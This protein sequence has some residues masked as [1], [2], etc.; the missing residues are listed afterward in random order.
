MITHNVVGFDAQTQNPNANFV[1]LLNDL[2][3]EGKAN[4]EKPLTF[5]RPILRTGPQDCQSR[6]IKYFGTSTRQAGSGKCKK[7]RRR[8]EK[9][10]L[11]F[12]IK[13]KRK[14]WAPVSHT[15]IPRFQSSSDR[16]R[17]MPRKVKKR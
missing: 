6:V 2:L 15:G 16:D 13:E 9:T 12:N 10:M 4:V 1:A 11:L 14:Y 7:K 8:R 17:A 3:L 5:A